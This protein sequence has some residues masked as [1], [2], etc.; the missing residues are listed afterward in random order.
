MILTPK[1][2]NFCF[3]QIPSPRNG[4]RYFPGIQEYPFS[5]LHIHTI[6]LSVTY[7]ETVSFPSHAWPSNM[8]RTQNMRGSEI[9]TTLQPTKSVHD[10]KVFVAFSGDMAFHGCHH[11]CLPIIFILA[12]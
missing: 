5:F 4:D 1:I 12:L 7:L 3:L 9:V 10:D 2:L 11:R 6:P 8:N